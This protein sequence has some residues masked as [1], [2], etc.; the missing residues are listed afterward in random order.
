MKKKLGVTDSK[1]PLADFLPA[2]TINAKGLAT[3]ITNINTSKKD[4]KGKVQIGSE[5]MQ[6]NDAV[7]RLLKERGITPEDLPA[8]EDIKEVQKRH[9]QET[10]LL[11]KEAKKKLKK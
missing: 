2:V 1:R 6:N 5:H 3:S 10:K 7:R 9:K 4:L 11:E 8:S